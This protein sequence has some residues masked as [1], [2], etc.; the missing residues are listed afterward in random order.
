MARKD[1]VGTLLGDREVAILGCFLFEDNDLGHHL[2]EHS[3]EFM[4]IIEKKIFPKYLEL[5][6]EFENGTSLS[7]P[8]DIE[9]TN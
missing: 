5:K 7:V 4:Q 8:S 9:P 6:K 2:D 1:R 3:V